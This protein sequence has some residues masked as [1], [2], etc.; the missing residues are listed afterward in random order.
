M[1]GRPPC[2][3]GPHVGPFLL[4]QFLDGGFVVGT[5]SIG[6]IT[7]MVSKA[8]RI[9]LVDHARLPWRFFGRLTAVQAGL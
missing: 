5:E 6:Y 4:A 1:R 9:I 2:K 3:K 8:Q 7:I